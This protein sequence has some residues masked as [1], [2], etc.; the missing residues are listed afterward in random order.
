MSTKLDQP[1]VEFARGPVEPTRSQRVD[2]ECYE[3]RTYLG[4]ELSP[5]PNEVKLIDSR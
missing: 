1:L 2:L 3:M 5:R 4:Y